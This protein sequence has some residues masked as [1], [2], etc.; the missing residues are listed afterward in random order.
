MDFLVPSQEYSTASQLM[1]G[2]VFT[3]RGLV[4]RKTRGRVQMME[5]P[6]SH[7][8][9][10]SEEYVFVEEEMSNVCVNTQKRD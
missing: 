4:K 7:R 2:W 9:Q 6:A 8:K 5:C 1:G 3:N 10:R